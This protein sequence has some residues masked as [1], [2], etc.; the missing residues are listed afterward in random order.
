MG[1][2]IEEEIIKNK[3]PIPINSFKNIMIFLLINLL[4]IALIYNYKKNYINIDT[5]NTGINWKTIFKIEM[6]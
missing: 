1:N 5:K 4:L 6:N 3:I 2:T